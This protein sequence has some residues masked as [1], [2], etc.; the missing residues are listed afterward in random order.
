MLLVA[1]AAVGS[2]LNVV[3]KDLGWKV[4]TQNAWQDDKGDVHFWAWGKLPTSGSMF[5]RYGKNGWWNQF[6]KPDFVGQRQYH[7]KTSTIAKCHTFQ[8]QAV[9]ITGNLVLFGEI[10]EFKTRGCP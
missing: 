3:F 1:P 4:Q 8:Y 2:D 7:W 5:I 6:T 10:K 9:L